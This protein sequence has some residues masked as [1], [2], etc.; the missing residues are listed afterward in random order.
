MGGVW[1]MLSSSSQDLLRLLSA[2]LLLQ[3]AGA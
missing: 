2:A 1:S 3:V